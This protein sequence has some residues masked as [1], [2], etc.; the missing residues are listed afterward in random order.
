MKKIVQLLFV[1]LCFVFFTSQ[2]NEKSEEIFSASWVRSVNKM[3]DEKDLPK[4]VKAS[5]NHGTQHMIDPLLILAVIRQESTFRTKTKNKSSKGLMQVIPY[6]HKDKI[7]GRDILDIDVN[8][9]VGTK[10]LAECKKRK[11]ENIIKVLNCYRGSDDKKYTA[12]VL[13]ARDN[14]QQLIIEEQF[15]QELPIYYVTQ[16]NIL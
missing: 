4:I 10:I 2:A 15:K 7:K 16:K 3:V 14:L 9:E 8:I 11:G 13:K 6:W 1:C 12:S 5:F